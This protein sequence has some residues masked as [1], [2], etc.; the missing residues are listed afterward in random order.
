MYTSSLNIHDHDANMTTCPCGLQD[1]SD[2][3]ALYHT[4][5][6]IP[7][8]PEALMR[9]RYAAYALANVDYIQQT[10]R[11]KSLAGFDKSKAKAAAESV[12][13]LGLKIIHTKNESPDCGFV[14][15]IARLIERGKQRSIHEISEFHRVDGKW[16]YVDGVHPVN[17]NKSLSVKIGRNSPCPCGSQKKF[18]NCHGKG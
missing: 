15:F 7:P 10:M 5:E 9:S 12:K 4:G 16:Y 11:G 6:R 8:T 13:W 18:K 2:C 17:Q 3:C 14:E 1:Y